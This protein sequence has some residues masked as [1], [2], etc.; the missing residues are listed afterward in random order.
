MGL[1]G[2]KDGEMLALVN[3]EIAKYNVKGIEELIKT[4][5]VPEH[6]GWEDLIVLERLFEEEKRLDEARLIGDPLEDVEMA[7]YRYPP[8]K[9]ISFQFFAGL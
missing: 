8:S 5:K 3:A 7:H 4:G 9:I 2:R 6:P 1:R